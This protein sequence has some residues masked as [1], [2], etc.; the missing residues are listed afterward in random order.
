MVAP[1]VALAIGCGSSDPT[2]DP[3][4][5]NLPGTTAP[6]TTEAPTGP[7]LASNWN[8]VRTAGS[9][10]VIAF[11]GLAPTTSPDDPCQSDYQAV[12]EESGDEVRV[13]VHGTHVDTCAEDIAYGRSLTVP[14]AE[15]LGRPAV[16]QRRHRAGGDR[17]STAA[18]SPTPPGCPDGWRAAV[19]PARRSAHR[20]GDSVAGRL[21]P[22]VIAGDVL[23]R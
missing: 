11:Y 7:V 2:A 21:G 18:G 5:P 13:T 16:G 9:D 3:T 4:A 22:A 1:L 10:L 15:P 12:V 20:T 6:A 23:W 8:G 19:G 14:L 17:R